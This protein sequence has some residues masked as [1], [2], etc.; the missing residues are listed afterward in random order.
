MEG[1]EEGSDW[2]L[3]GDRKGREVKIIILFILNNIQIY[4]HYTCKYVY[5]VEMQDSSPPRNIRLI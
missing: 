5:T 4:T 3:L 1:R 2:F